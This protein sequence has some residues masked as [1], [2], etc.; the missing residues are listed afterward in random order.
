MGMRNEEERLYLWV[1]IFGAVLLLLAL[2]AL[3]IFVVV[4]NDDMPE[5]LAVI[6]LGTLAT[7]ALALVDVQLRLR[8]NG[9]SSKES[10]NADDKH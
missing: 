8:R 6:V 2:V 1:R 4:A 9:K 10:E 7:S 5:G 3:A